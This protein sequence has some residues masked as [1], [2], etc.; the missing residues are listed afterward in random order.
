MKAKIRYYETDTVWKYALLDEQ[1]DTIELFKTF[2]SLLK[3]AVAHR[4][5]IVK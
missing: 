4:I 5:Q 3:Y 2:M 1:G